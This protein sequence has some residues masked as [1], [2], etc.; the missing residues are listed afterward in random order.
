MYGTYHVPST[1]YRTLH[2][3]IHLSFAV[4]LQSMFSHFTEDKTEPQWL[5]NESMAELGLEP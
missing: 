4:A 3:V 2:L 5:S 1:F